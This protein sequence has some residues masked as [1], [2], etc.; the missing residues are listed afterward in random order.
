MISSYLN[1][2]RGLLIINSHEDI[3]HNE[4]RTVRFMHKSSTQ[5]WVTFPAPDHRVPLR[6]QVLRELGACPI[7]PEKVGTTDIAVEDFQQ[8]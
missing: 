1:R 4:L 8:L 3:P 6:F 5:G 7:V 2:E